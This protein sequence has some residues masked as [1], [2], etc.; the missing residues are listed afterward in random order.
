MGMGFCLAENQ[1]P[2]KIKQNENKKLANH[3]DKSNQIPS[4]NSENYLRPAP[5]SDRFNRKF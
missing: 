5:D 3:R 2:E 4:Q 1:Q